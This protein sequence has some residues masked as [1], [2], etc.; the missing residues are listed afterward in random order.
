MAETEAE[1]YDVVGAIMDYED[2]SQSARESLEMF[3]HLIKT[4]AIRGLQGS[5]QRAASDIV[6]AGYLTPDGDLTEFALA[7]LEEFEG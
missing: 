5:Y 4:G 3:S 6:D 7:R 1:K 2:G